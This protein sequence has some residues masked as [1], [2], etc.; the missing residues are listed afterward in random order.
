MRTA[1][2]LML[3]VAGMSYADG[4][5]YPWLTAPAAADQSFSA[6]FA[7]PQGFERRECGPTCTWWRGLPLK[8]GRPDV[9]LHD[10]RTKPNQSA[11]LAVLELDV[12][13]RDLQQCADAVLR[14]WAE[15]AFARNGAA[16]LCIPLTSGAPL[17]W[18][19]WADGERPVVKGASL[20]WSRRGGPDAGH[21][22]F[23]RYLDFAFTYAGTASVERTMAE[24]VPLRD[25]RPGDFFIQGGFPGHAVM[26]LDVVEGSGGQRAFA[27]AQS[28]MPAQDVHVLDNPA[29]PGSPWY[30]L[31]EAEALVTPEWTFAPGAL[32]RFRPHP[33]RCP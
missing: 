9:K 10:G 6:R 22:A 11:H 1:P 21:A 33:A 28:Y 4:R 26:V 31:A 23:R 20:E 7:P 12:G 30:E 18:K 32:A 25:I 29:R 27:L 19:R 17:T 2:A 13:K 14:L 3:L 24:K 5:D 16:D 15:H 8:P